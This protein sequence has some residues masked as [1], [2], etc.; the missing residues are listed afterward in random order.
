[1][2]RRDSAAFEELSAELQATAWELALAVVDEGLVDDQVPSLQRLGRLGQLGDLPT[3]IAELGRELGEPLAEDRVRHGSPLAI[4]ARDH[5]R[6]REALGFAPRE[7]VTEF[8]LLRRVLWRFVAGRVAGLDPAH[9]LTAEQRL[10]TTIDRLVTECVVA[11]FDRAT[12]ELAHQARHDQLTGLLHHQA[13]VREL[14]LELERAARYGHGVAL[15]FLDLDRFKE[16]NDSLGHPAGDRVLQR[17]GALLRDS[18]RGS[19]LA[20]RMGGDEFAAYLVEADEEAGSRLL[21]R[22]DDRVDELVA[23]GELPAPCSFSAGLAHFPDEA[24]DADALFRLAD[25]RLYE[26]KRARIA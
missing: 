4:Q 10:N 6:Q 1:M 15:V 23:A 11:Y 12:S 8:L 9:M 2:T 14:D 26:T 21:S 22:L 5:A 24:A 3:F 7:I 13:F 25:Q 19:D 17:L 20:G 16:I 18:L